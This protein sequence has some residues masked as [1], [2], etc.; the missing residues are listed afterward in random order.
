VQRHIGVLIGPKNARTGIIDPNV[1]ASE[2]LFGRL[3]E[4]LHSRGIG[5][6]CRHGK[7]TTADRPAFRRETFENLAT[8]GGKDYTGAPLCEGQSGGTA[9]PAGS[10]GY[11]Y[12][13]SGH[14]LRLCRR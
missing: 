3:S 14:L 10:S 2:G 6:V 13:R 4:A 7:R 8:S 9:D 11:D 1:D 12:A 5:Y